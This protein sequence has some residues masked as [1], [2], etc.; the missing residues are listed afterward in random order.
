MDRLFYLEL[1]FSNYRYFPDWRAYPVVLPSSASS[2]DCRQTSACCY[3]NLIVLAEPEFWAWTQT[4]SRALELVRR[5]PL[6]TT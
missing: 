3:P 1:Y 4:E 2:L 6:G 5:I